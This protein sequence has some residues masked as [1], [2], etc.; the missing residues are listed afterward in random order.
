M[1]LRDILYIMTQ[2][3]YAYLFYFQK[4]SLNCRFNINCSIVLLF[5][6]RDFKYI[7]TYIWPIFH[8]E[9]FTLNLSIYFILIIFLVLQCNLISSPFE[10]FVF[11]FLQ[12][13]PFVFQYRSRDCCIF[14]VI[15]L[16][17]WFP[18]EFLILLDIPSKTFQ[19]LIWDI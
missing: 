7:C 19:M 18:F 10:Q 4:V 3:T 2:Y 8:F 6:F 17:Q 11:Y 12:F 14:F 15:W 16:F 5:F 9:F 13:L 1:Q